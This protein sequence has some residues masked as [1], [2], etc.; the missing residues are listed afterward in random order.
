MGVSQIV[1]LP[2]VQFEGLHWP[3]SRQPLSQLLVF[4]T[5][6]KLSPHA[7][8]CI[9]Q[10]LQSHIECT[11]DHTRGLLEA[12]ASIAE[13]AVHPLQDIAVMFAHWHE[14][15]PVFFRSVKLISGL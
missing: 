14:I 12:R 7:V 11:R 6:T 5:V 8:Q 1:A 15:S 2:D 10:F 3:I 4:W 13:S 9:Q